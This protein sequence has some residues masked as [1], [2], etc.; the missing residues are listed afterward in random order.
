MYKIGILIALLIL[1]IIVYKFTQKETFDPDFVYAS[2][3]VSKETKQANSSVLSNGTVQKYF[4]NGVYMY[5]LF[6]NLPS[7][8]GIFQTNDLD[9]PFNEPG[10]IESYKVYAGSSKKDL[11]FVG[12]LTRVPNGNHELIFTSEKNYKIVGIFLG[13]TLVEYVE[14]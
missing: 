3:L 2:D 10:P 6:F 13:D 7:T 11:E 5:N 1:A 14:F 9:R 4:E 12:I 8:G